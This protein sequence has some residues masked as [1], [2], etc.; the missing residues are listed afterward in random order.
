VNPN[1]P[2]A[3][4]PRHDADYDAGEL[5]C[6]DL[7]L[8]LSVEMKKLAGGDVLRLRADDP[9]APADIPAWCGLTGHT[10]LAQEPPMYWIR[11]RERP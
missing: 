11:R 8:K 5:G 9:G 10:L 3:S 7:V 6:G 4:A 1:R 2:D